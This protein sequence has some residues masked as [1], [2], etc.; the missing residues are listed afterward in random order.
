MGVPVEIGVI[1]NLTQEHLD[2]H[3]TMN[4]YAAAKA[5]LFKNHG[6]KYAVLNRDDKWYPFFAKESRAEEFT[7]GKH[8]DA[9]VKLSKIKLKGKESSAVF[10]FAQGKITAK[11]SLLGE[12]NLY[13]AAAAASVGILLSLEPKKIERGLSN[14]ARLSGRM[15]EVDAGQRFKV[16]VDFAITPDAIEK[17]LIS[18]REI[19]KG[20]IRIV[21]GATGDR[22][23]TKRPLMG[24]AAAKNAD[25]IYLTDDETYT[26]NSQDIIDSVYEGIEEF[27][28][29]EKTKVIPDREKAIKQAIKNAKPGDAI[30]ITGLGH[31]PSRNMGGKLI[32]WSDREIAEKYL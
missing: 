16:I 29:A 11:T 25:F 23:K 30:L 13:N 20:K 24:K 31:Q 28:A 1:T 15:E 12:F 9:D 22:D 14:L 5:L 19:T 2:Y 21:F 8:K 32:P 26:E 10:S 17:V 27:K 6:A 4:R 3:K 18:L 7:Y